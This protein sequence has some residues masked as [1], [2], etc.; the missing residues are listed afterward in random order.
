[1]CSFEK[2]ILLWFTF[3]LISV[4]QILLME[5]DFSRQNN[6]AA[7][8]RYDMTTTSMTWH[9]VCKTSEFSLFNDRRWVQNTRSYFKTWPMSHICRCRAFC[10]VMLHWNKIYR[11]PDI[12]SKAHG[13]RKKNTFRWC[14]FQRKCKYLKT[15]ICTNQSLTTVVK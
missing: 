10:D 8:P 12:R 3:K 13:F 11:Q 2:N 6:F 7:F 4:F 14:H 9:T 15:E 1:M 5:W